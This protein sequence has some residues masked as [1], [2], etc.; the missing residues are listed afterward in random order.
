MAVNRSGPPCP[1][2]GSLV[3]DV[4]R[5]VRTNTGDFWRRRDCPSCGV[6]F[7]TV[8]AAELVAPAGSVSWH[9]RIPTIHWAKFRNYFA[10]LLRHD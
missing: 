7:F 1:E 3:T 5:T 10:E 2:C 4:N 8:Q 9:Y 6:T